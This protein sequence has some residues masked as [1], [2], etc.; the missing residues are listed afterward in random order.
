MGQAQRIPK[1]SMCV[2]IHL[3]SPQMLSYSFGTAVLLPRSMIPSHLPMSQSVV[4]LSSPVTFVLPLLRWAGLPACLLRLWLRLRR[5]WELMAKM[6]A[7]T[8]QPVDLS[9]SDPPDPHAATKTV[10][11]DRDERS[12]KPRW[13]S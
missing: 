6:E 4:S 8:G 11:H 13:V 2:G 12:G 5:Q 7:W 10:A 3:G 9:V 1:T